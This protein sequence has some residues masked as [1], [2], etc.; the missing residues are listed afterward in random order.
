MEEL[1][2]LLG[3]KGMQRWLAHRTARPAIRRQEGEEQAR[4]PPRPVTHIQGEAWE[5]GEVAAP[6]LGRAA[7]RFPG[8]SSS[9]GER[10]ARAERPRPG[11]RTHPRGLL[12]RTFQQTPVDGLHL[13][14]QLRRHLLSFSPALTPLPPPRGPRPRHSPNC[15]DC[16]P[17]PR[18]SVWS[19]PGGRGWG[20]RRVVWGKP[21]RREGGLLRSLP[22]SAPKSQVTASSLPRRRTQRTQDLALSLASTASGTGKRAITPKRGSRIAWEL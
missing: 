5:P 8:V 6:S 9:P 15:R 11:P 12:S 2:V 21:D 7:P 22:G 14:L 1:S 4:W 18:Q 16:H 20:R 3:R 10:P 13:G 19:R 17:C